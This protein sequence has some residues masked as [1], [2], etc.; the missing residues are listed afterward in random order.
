MDDNK[1]VEFIE[2]FS[3]L[4]KLRIKL[5]DLDALQCF[6]YLNSSD[7]GHID[8]NQFCNLVEER[9]RGLDPFTK[10]SSP[11]KKI[12]NNPLSDSPLK[13]SEIGGS[14]ISEA[15]DLRP[16]HAHKHYLANIK[17]EDLDQL[18]KL[19]ERHFI[20]RK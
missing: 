13:L 6:K 15:D 1:T 2:F 7:D 9:R 8:Y 3:G 12:D 20:E 11:S 17:T 16:D 14:M 4:D 10:S 18:L 5:S 19:Q